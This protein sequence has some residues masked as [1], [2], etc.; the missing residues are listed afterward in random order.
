[1]GNL[2]KMNLRLAL[3]S[4]AASLLVL[5]P[6]LAQ[7]PAPAPAPSAAEAT[8]DEDAAEVEALIVTAAARQPGAV[9]GDIP[10]ELQFTPR[11][12][13]A[14]G[15]SSVSEL[16]SAL[17]TQLTT[18]QSR[19]AG[20]RPV[21]LV[22]GVR[23]SSFREIRDVPSEAILRAD[24]L[25]EEV[26]LK[27]GYPADTR[28]MNLVLRPRFRA[29]TVEAGYK[30]ST[31]VVGGDLGDARVNLFSV[32]DASRLLIDA[33]VTGQSDLLESDVDLAVPRTDAAF[34]TLTPQQT[35]SA[36]NVV[37]TRQLA[38]GLSGTLN[39][40]LENSNSRSR[41]GLNALSTG[42]ALQRESNSVTGHL[43]GGLAGA[44]STWRW[45]ATANADRSDN[46]SNTQRVV[47]G[48]GYTDTTNAVSTSYD[49]ELVVNGTAFRLPAGDVSTTFTA[50]AESLNFK[51]QSLRANV[52]AEGELSRDSLTAKINVDVPVFRRGRFGPEIL[53][54][55][56]LNLNA[57]TE[58]L[59]DFGRLGTVGAGLNWA[60]LSK[61]RFIASYS[62]E[63]GPP[64][65]QQVGNPVQITPGV[66]AY[67]FTRGETA[68]INRIE[69]GNTA[70][71]A[72]SRQVVKLGM[73]LK[74]FEK[75]DLN[76]QANYVYTKIDDVIAS[77]PTAT[78]QI[79]AAFADRF[80]RDATGRL[81]SIDARPVNFDGRTTEQLRY[82]FS[83]RRSI[84]PQPP[85]RPPGGF[86]RP[87]GA[88][89]GPGGQRGQGAA[90]AQGQAQAPAAAPGA[91]P[92]APVGGAPPSAPPPGA[93]PGGRGGFGGPSGGGGF[94]GGGPRGGG[95][96][97]G[98][99]QISLFHTIKFQDVITIRPGV[100]K[101]DLLDGAAIGNGGGVARNQFDLQGNINRRGL[102]A[103]LNVR[104]SEGTKISGSG[105]TGSQDLFFADL[106]SV[107]LRFFAE[108]RQ[109]PWFRDHAFFRG[110][111]AQLAI[112]NL[113]DQKQEVRTADGLT[114]QTYQPNYLDP[115]GRTIRLS[116]R[117]LF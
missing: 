76:F 62:A 87:A 43:G 80:T 78:S 117:K 6:A 26:A 45:T 55:V 25:P 29:T 66:Q 95:G 14:L 13:N 47:N 18:G 73:N 115:E 98:T 110:A 72:D 59:S 79:E 16:I 82:G 88:A 86:Q 3:L 34:R 39:G 41:L 46:E 89:G 2:A 101:L 90:G 71:E 36:L 4:G 28:V 103:N 84:G 67:D 104:W 15:V 35:T 20:G 74:P 94:G 23:V 106:A 17:S 116:F 105:A 51:T 113:F 24:I 111:R 57:A 109:Q 114:P 11:D 65:V 108:L 75:H 12:I 102:G 48:I 1:M 30:A 85:A 99:M 10:P 107:N 63:Q 42:S 22:N 70:L 38:E 7:T 27:Y 31:E 8:Y 112:E 44:I 77:F 5:N 52:E 37:V 58:E 83:F 91:A 96:G 33:K 61:L 81:I 56:S 40:T 50:G 49:A 64:T 53:G 54:D 97:G 60:P 100:P 32:L 93:G 68:I 9:I 92:Q 69:G 19:E 21:I